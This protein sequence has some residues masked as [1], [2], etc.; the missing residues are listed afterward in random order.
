M[1]GGW[2]IECSRCAIILENLFLFAHFTRVEFGTESMEIKGG[3]S[4]F[5]LSAK[6]PFNKTY[7]LWAKRSICLMPVK[8]VRNIERNLYGNL[9]LKELLKVFFFV[10]RQ[11]ANCEHPPFSQDVDNGRVSE[12]VWHRPFMLNLLL[13]LRQLIVE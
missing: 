12:T 9:S 3:S 4:S 2:L 10:P 13:I 11:W 8:R 5:V 1:R 7:K 6:M